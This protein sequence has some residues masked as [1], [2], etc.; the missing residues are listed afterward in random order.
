[1]QGA[2]RRFTGDKLII[3]T[4]NEGKLREFAEMLAPYVKNIVAS[5]ALGLPEPE[6][7][8]TTFVENA[9]LKALAAARA[10]GSAALADD[11]GLC[12]TALDGRPGL[13]SARWAG[14]K[15]DFKMAMQRVHDELGSAQNRA[16][17]FDCAL[18][19]AWPDGH[20]EAVAGD[21]P[22][23]LVWPPRGDKGH[24]YD[25]MF[26]PD[27]HDKTFAEMDAEEKNELSHRG[28]AVRALIAQCFA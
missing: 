7:T 16:A 11:S 24:G 10:S 25:P 9:A 23:L 20:L 19:L 27:G 2:P 21:V 12:V 5:G 14:P 22:G 8:G 13:F 26:V 6:E 18:V 17:A 3:A 28:V 15:K 4:H 1:M